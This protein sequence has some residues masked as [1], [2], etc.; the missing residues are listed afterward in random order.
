[1][2]QIYCEECSCTIDSKDDL[3][4]TSKFFIPVAYHR[5]CYAEVLKGLKTFFVDN[6]PI[7]GA[8]ATLT[9]FF[10]VIIWALFMLTSMEYKILWTILFLTLPIYRLLAWYLFERHVPD[11]K[12]EGFH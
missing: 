7:N 11:K 1:M 5:A 8:A 12:S 6:V 9:S 10:S 4:I 2:K 3:I